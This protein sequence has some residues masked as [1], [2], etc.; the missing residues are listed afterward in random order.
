[1]ESKYYAYY[2]PNYKVELMNDIKTQLLE[3]YDSLI[4]NKLIAQI[5][6]NINNNDTDEYLCCDKA[7]SLILIK[8]TL[9]NHIFITENNIDKNNYTLISKTIDW[10]GKKL[11]NNN[12]NQHYY[13]CDTY[14]TYNK[15]QQILFNGSTNNQPITDETQYIFA[16]YLTI[17][18]IQILRLYKDINFDIKST[19]QPNTSQFIKSLLKYEN[20][21]TLTEPIIKHILELLNNILSSE[22]N[23]S[24]SRNYCI[25]NFTTNENVLSKHIIPYQIENADLV[26]TL[27]NKLYKQTDNVYEIFSNYKIIIDNTVKYKSDDLKELLCCNVYSYLYI[28]QKQFSNINYKD[29]LPFRL[30]FDTKF[31]FNGTQVLVNHNKEVDDINRHT[32]EINRVKQIIDKFLRTKPPTDNCIMRQQDIIN[33]HEAEIVNIKLR[34]LKINPYYKE[35]LLFHIN[36][37]LKL[38]FESE[39]NAYKSLLYLR[40]VCNNYDRLNYEI[41]NSTHPIFI[42]SYDNITDKRNDVFQ[43]HIYKSLLNDLVDMKIKPDLFSLSRLFNIITEDKYQDGKYKITNHEINKSFEITNKTSGNYKNFC[44]FLTEHINLNLFEYQKNNLLWMLQLEDNID[45]HK[46][47]IDAYYN[48]FSMSNSYNFENLQDIKSFIYRLKHHIPEVIVKDYYINHNNKKYV[49]DIENKDTIKNTL[50]VISALNACNHKHLSRISYN[51]DFNVIENI[52]KPN[53]YKEKYNKKIEFCGGAICDEVGLGKTLTIISH[54][55]LK[56]KHDMSKYNNYKKDINDLISRLSNTTDTCSNNFIDPLDKGFEYNNLIIVPS[57]LTSQWENEIE[58]YVKNKFNLRA[59]VLIGINSIK[60]LEHE[61]T[62]FHIKKCKASSSSST[63]TT[64]SSSRSNTEDPKRK[65]KLKTKETTAVTPSIIKLDNHNQP[66]GD[67]ITNITNII[68]TID[69]NITELKIV[70]GEPIKKQTKEQKMIEKLMLKAKKDNDKFKKDVIKETPIDNTKVEPIKKKLILKS[71]PNINNTLNCLL[72]SESES[73]VEPIVNTNIVDT[74]ID[75]PVDEPVVDNNIVE[76]E[77]E[78]SY[79]DKYLKCHK[80]NMKESE[81]EYLS[82]QLYDI[83]IVSS[84]LL[85]NENYLQYINHSS[86]NCYTPYYEGETDEIKHLNKIK[87]IKEHHK[88][89]STYDTDNDKKKKHKNTDCISVDGDTNN[90]SASSVHIPISTK[91]NYVYQMSRLTEKFN[92]FK[93]KWNRVILDEA[94]EKLSPII[95]MFSTSMS[96]YTDRLKSVTNEGQFY[97]EN[98][99]II[100]SNYKWAMSGTPVEQGIDSIMGIL[101][102]L[103]VKD[104]NDDLIT[105]IDKVRYLRELIGISPDNMDILLNTVFKKTFKKDVKT[106]LNIPIFTEEVIYVEQTNIERNIYNSIRGSRYLSEAVKIRTLFLMCTNILINNEI[107]LMEDNDGS[108]TGT[109]TGTGSGNGSVANDVCIEALTLEQLNTNMIAKFTQQVKLLEITKTKLIKRNSELENDV[110]SWIALIDYIT[111]LNLDEIIASDILLDINNKFSD[112]TNTR[113]R[114]NCDVFYNILS[115]YE[116]W[117]NPNTLD[118]ILRTHMNDIKYQL[119]SLWNNTWVNNLSNILMKCS[120]F[121][122]KLG[123]IKIRDEISKNLKKLSTF[124]SDKTRIINQ[125]TLFSNNEFLTDKTKDPCI[126][127]FDDLTDFVVT[128]CRHIF[129]L[130]CIKKLS[131]DLK[132]NFNCPECRAPIDRKSLN[133]TNVEMI[134]KKEEV[135]DETVIGAGDAVGCEGSSTH[136]GA[137]G[138]AE[139]TVLEKKLGKDWKTSCINRYGSKMQMLIQ[140]L[141]TIFDDPTNRVIIFSQYDKMLKMIGKTLEEFK[142]KF[143]HCSGNNYVLNKNIMKFKKDDSYRVIMLSAEN[144]NSG[145]NLTE[146]SHVLL[147]DVLQHNTEQTKAIEFQAIGRAI[148]LGQSLSVKIVRFIT[149]GTIEEEHFNANRYDINIFQS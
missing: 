52:I 129:C 30:S 41:D 141:Y 102:F 21:G 53:T 45:A 148:R 62:E 59:K 38:T 149:K 65:L 82:N 146:S 35:H 138:S 91:S 93:I 58:K 28:T 9:V 120:T 115:V 84:N 95:K 31:N 20:N 22:N 145:A 135:V 15:T 128:P 71:K 109:G 60:S 139:L 29:S 144:A 103:K 49:I 100:N 78:Y 96:R 111:N 130:T 114:A 133:I 37:G 8:F 132:T 18:V 32:S 51:D 17:P 42:F 104:Y 80:T 27:W 98:L 67:S 63:S 105:Q 124:D 118:F 50:S 74:N 72:N 108:G 19:V 6:N 56:L 43:F 12:N 134:N 25:S 46:V 48:K 40:Y 14:N 106:L 126:I 85:F 11:K 69:N 1:M 73:V 131:S 123:E 117:K 101:Q 36:T 92:I 13:T 23:D 64:S 83:Y 86:I 140:Y 3:E 99:S 112:L 54:L 121:G 55:V 127:C 34:L 122:A 76:P 16:E 2:K 79:V 4:V 5:Y 110:S 88:N 142:I 137:S 7:N 68:D 81:N 107:N 26:I 116:V 97:Y 39:L 66:S 33:Y 143:V 136:G 57:R 75:E 47:T 61:L 44:K 125:I 119:Y 94:H 147:I 89:H 90:L 77:D 87:I 24:N 70:E 10:V 113:I